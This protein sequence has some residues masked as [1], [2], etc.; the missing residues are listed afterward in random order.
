MCEDVSVRGGCS[1]LFFNNLFIIESLTQKYL[2]DAG[3]GEWNVPG[4]HS[5]KI[6]P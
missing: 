5:L 2:K 6:G 1:G 4:N 3:L